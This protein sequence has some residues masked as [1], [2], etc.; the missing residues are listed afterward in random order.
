MKKFSGGILMNFSF[1]FISLFCILYSLRCFFFQR[2]I[3]KI[4]RLCMIVTICLTMKYSSTHVL[5]I[6]HHNVLRGRTEE[7]V[8][9]GGGHRARERRRE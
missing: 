1:R 6:R 9:R 2:Q 4:E 5:S 3:A 7:G 8:E